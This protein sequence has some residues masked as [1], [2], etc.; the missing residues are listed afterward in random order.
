MLSRKRALG[1]TFD[2]MGIVPELSTSHR[3]HLARIHWFYCLAALATSF[4][5]M[6]SPL[7]T[8][9]LRLDLKRH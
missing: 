9:G 3:V 1:A 8:G 7:Y 5:Y 6:T 4:Q 2:G